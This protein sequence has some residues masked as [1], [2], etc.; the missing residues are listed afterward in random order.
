M[1]HEYVYS[2]DNIIKGIIEKKSSCVKKINTK[3][4][5]WYGYAGKEEECRVLLHVTELSEMRSAG[6]SCT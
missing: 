2:S 1:F 4:Y 5:A 3:E 6:F